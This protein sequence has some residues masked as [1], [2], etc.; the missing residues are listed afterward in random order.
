LNELGK[1]DSARQAFQ[2]ALQNEGLFLYR[3]KCQQMLDQL[4]GPIKS[5][6]PEPATT[7]TP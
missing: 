2:S 1:K 7:E 3:K 6:L 4:G 5:D